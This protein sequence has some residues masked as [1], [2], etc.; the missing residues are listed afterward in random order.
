MATQVAVGT[1][2][3]I[4]KAISK[5]PGVY[6][7]VTIGTTTRTLGMTSAGK[8]GIGFVEGVLTGKVLLDT[9]VYIGALV[10]CSVQ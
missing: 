1:V 3:S 10:V 4:G 8:F 7:P 9:G 6:N 2:T 5:M